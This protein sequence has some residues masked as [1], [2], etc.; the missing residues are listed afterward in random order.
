MSTGG[1]HEAQSTQGRAYG[2]GARGAGFTL[3]E[4]VVII[5][6]VG[7]LAVFLGPR[8]F[9][10]QVFS[11]RG[12][13]DELAFALRFSQKTAVATG[14][15]AQLTLTSNSYA[16]AQQA[17]LG[18]GCNPA[19]TTWSTPVIGA[20]GNAVQGSAPSNTSVSPTGVF[21]FDDQGR[22][23]SSPATTL[24]IGSRSITIDSGSGDVQVQ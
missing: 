4:L 14:C 5:A 6:I 19:D 1:Q 22:L 8:F 16:A 9:T 13:A 24:T 10:Q 3:T 12:Y 20:D 23:S 18:N 2:A 7:I 21:Q 17:A 11:D 15:P